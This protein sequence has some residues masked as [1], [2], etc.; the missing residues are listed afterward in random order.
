MLQCE[1]ILPELC[2]RPRYS[3]HVAQRLRIS[4]SA[5]QRAVG[6]KSL[7]P[8]KGLTS[9]IIVVDTKPKTDAHKRQAE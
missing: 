5:L 6:S 1:F 8:R 4:E 2:V 7:K 3:H 9:S